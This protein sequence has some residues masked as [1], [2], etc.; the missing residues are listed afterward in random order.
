MVSK[1][2]MFIFK[3]TFLQGGFVDEGLGRE[4]E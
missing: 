2:L 3:G 1:S 4:E